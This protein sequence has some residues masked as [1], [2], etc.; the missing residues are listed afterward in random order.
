MLS[1]IKRWIK[2]KS[3]INSF[4]GEWIVNP[5]LRTYIFNQKYSFGVTLEELL[6]HLWWT[7]KVS[8][9]GVKVNRVLA[10]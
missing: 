3:I 9:N 8:E 1:R 2:F 5:H 6:E 7:V 10:R 4:T